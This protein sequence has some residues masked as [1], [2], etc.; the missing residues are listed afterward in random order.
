LHL[1]EIIGF[2]LRA[3][4]YATAAVLRREAALGDKA[5]THWTFLRLMFQR[6]F[7]G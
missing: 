5:R 1:I 2:G 6:E 4:I 7:R 3:V